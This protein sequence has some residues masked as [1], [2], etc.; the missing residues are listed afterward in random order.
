M[1]KLLVN[2]FVVLSG[3]LEVRTNNQDGGLCTK[4]QEKMLVAYDIDCYVIEYNLQFKN[5]FFAF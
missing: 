4:T 3:G 5:M 2:R 1:E